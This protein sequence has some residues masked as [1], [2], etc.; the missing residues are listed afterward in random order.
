MNAVAVVTLLIIV[1]VLGLFLYVGLV[2]WRNRK[3]ERARQVSGFAE[4]PRDLIPR[5]HYPP[6]PRAT[7]VQPYRKPT[8]IPESRRDDSNDIMNPM[9]VMSPLHASALDFGGS[10]QSSSYD[11]GPSCDAGSSISDSGSSSGCISSD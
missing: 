2:R 1:A 7:P 5:R 8:P 4:Y 6:M 9:N 10:S 11:P 3:M